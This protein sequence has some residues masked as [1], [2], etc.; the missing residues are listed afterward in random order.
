VIDSSVT[1]QETLFSLAEE[2]DKALADNDKTLTTQ[3][4]ELWTKYHEDE[5]QEQEAYQQKLIDLQST[6]QEKQQ[7]QVQKYQEGLTKLH[8]DWQKTLQTAED[9]A[10]DNALSALDTKAK[11]D[12]DFYQD[13]EKRLADWNAK[14]A[15]MEKQGATCKIDAEKEAFAESEREAAK[16]YLEAEQAQRESLGRQ[17]IDFTVAQALKNNVSGE[18]LDQMITGIAQATGMYDSTAA[19]LLGDTFSGISQ[20]AQSGGQGAHGVLASVQALPGAAMEARIA[21]DKLTD[22]LIDQSVSAYM[23]TGN[24]DQ[25]MQSLQGIPTNVATQMGLSVTDNKSGLL[26]QHQTYLNSVEQAQ[27]DHNKAMSDLDTQYQTDLF[28]AGGEHQTILDGLNEQRI[29]DLNQA[30]T[31]HQTQHDAIL[32]TYNKD[33]GQ[34]KIDYAKDIGNALFAAGLSNNEV[35]TFLEKNL[36][37]ILTEIDTVNKKMQDR[38]NDGMNPVEA[39]ALWASDMDNTEYAKITGLQGGE[40]DD[41]FLQMIEEQRQA[42]LTLEEERAKAF[43]TLNQTLLIDIPAWYEESKEKILTTHGMQITELK[44]QLHEMVGDNY[45]AYHQLA[46]EEAM[47]MFRYEKEMQSKFKSLSKEDLSPEAFYNQYAT[48]TE[49]GVRSLNWRENRFSGQTVGIA[50]GTTTFNP[51]FKPTITI[52]IDGK[53]LADKAITSTVLQQDYTA[54]QKTGGL[55]KP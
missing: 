26:E 8:E 47:Y 16:A 36:P 55:S 11:T 37:T 14:R 2:K 25:Y 28:H 53:A 35:N 30:L 19:S 48:L 24:V 21:Q 1:Q 54:S 27:R 42:W 5:A 39:A 33:V 34:A 12:A 52:N 23:A 3:K 43:A 50:T 44:K 4:K 13:A 49:Q 10:R 6:Y 18:A 31:E 15:L 51:E 40:A 46:I 17:L 7:A 32:A 20:W 29:T 45:E 9:K 38:I 41:S 22:S